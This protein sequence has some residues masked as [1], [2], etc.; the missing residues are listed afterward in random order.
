MWGRYTSEEQLELVFQHLLS[1]GLDARVVADLLSVFSRRE[2]PR[3]D[4]RLFAFCRHEDDL[5]RHKA[6]HALEMLRHPAVRNFGIDEIENH[7]NPKAVKLLTKNFEPGDEERI[8][9][10]IEPPGDVDQLHWLLM[11]MIHVLEENPAADASRLAVAAYARTPC[12]NCRSRAY[13]QL[14]ARSMVP[15]WMLEEFKLDSYRFGDH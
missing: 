9:R 15:G 4:D 11:D 2:F 12:T 14:E 6:F 13:D 5:V 7:G 8:L 1:P 3:L 10:S